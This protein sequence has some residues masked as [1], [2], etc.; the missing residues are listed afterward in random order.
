[1]PTT[2]TVMTSKERSVFGA[3]NV[4]CVLRV[5][6]L[7]H[8]I[9]GCIRQSFFRYM[10]D[11]ILL[12]K[13]SNVHIMAELKTTIMLKKI[14][15]TFRIKKGFLYIIKTIKRLKNGSQPIREK[16]FHFQEKFL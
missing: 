7:Y 4:M 6:C 2:P 5:P 12:V 9:D 13:H 1:M 16:Q 14:S 3:C 15:S 11:G 10:D 8:T